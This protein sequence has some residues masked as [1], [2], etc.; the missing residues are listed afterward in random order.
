ISQHFKRAAEHKPPRTPLLAKAVDERHS[1]KI[2][3]YLAPNHIVKN[4]VAA[5]SADHDSSSGFSSMSDDDD[6]DDEDDDN[7]E[8]NHINVNIGTAASTN[9]AHRNLNNSNISAG[10]HAHKSTNNGNSSNGINISNPRARNENEDDSDESDDD[11]DV[12]GDEDDDDDDEDDEDEDDDDGDL[13]GDSTERKLKRR[14]QHQLYQQH[15]HLS[16]D[17]MVHKSRSVMRK[18]KKVKTWTVTNRPT[19]KRFKSKHPL[20]GSF[21]AST[22]TNIHPSRWRPANNQEYSESEDGDDESVEEDDDL[23]DD[24]DVF[25]KGDL[26]LMDLQMPEIEKDVHLPTTRPLASFSTPPP[27]L[28]SPHTVSAAI[29]ATAGMHGLLNATKILSFDSKKSPP[30]PGTQGIASLSDAMTATGSVDPMVESSDE[31]QDFSDYHE[32]MMHGDFDDLD[33]DKR[34]ED[35]RSGI[36]VRSQPQAVAVPIPSVR[37]AA[38]SSSSFAAGGTPVSP[39]SHL[40]STPTS[41]S[42]MG[43]SPR[44]RKMSM[45]GLLMPPDSLLLSPRSNSIFDSDFG[46]SLMVDYSQDTSSSKDHQYV[47]L[48]E[49]NNPE[50]M[51]VSELDRLLSSSAGGTF[52]PSLSR[53]V[54]ISGW[55]NINAKHIGH[56]PHRQSNLRNAANGILQNAANSSFNASTSLYL[57]TGG[58][59]FSSIS[60]PPSTMNGGTKVAVFAGGASAASL[61]P[62]SASKTASSPAT[63]PLPSQQFKAGAAVITITPPV[64]TDNFDEGKRLQEDVEMQGDADEALDDETESELED[65]DETRSGSGAGSAIAAEASKSLVREAVY[66]NL[67]VYETVMPGTDL[68]LMRIAGVVAPPDPN[69]NGRGVV[70]QKKVIPALNNEQHAGFVNA[71]MLRLAARTYI[72]DGQFDINQEPTTLFIVLEGPMEV[73]GAWVGLARAR[74]LCHEY[75]LDVI[76]GIAQ[77]LQDKPME[78]INLSELRAS[79]REKKLKQKRQAAKD[80]ASSNM[81]GANRRTSTSSTLSNLSI[82]EGRRKS[83]A[84]DDDTTPFVNFE[85]LEEKPKRSVDDDVEM[86]SSADMMMSSGQTADNLNAPAVTQQGGSRS[87]S[88]SSQ[89]TADGAV[90][91][92]GAREPEANQLWIPTTSPVVPNIHLTVIDNVA[93]YTTKLVNPGAEYRLL[94]RADNGYVNATTLL[95]AGGVETEQERS[96][97]LSLELGRVRVRKPGSQ[98][99]G[100]W[101]PLARARALAATC[102]LHHKLGPFL[103]DNLDTYFPSPLP[104]PTQKVTPSVV[105][106]TASALMSHQAVTSARMRTISLSALRSSTSPP[107]NGLARA[108]ALN[109]Q[110]SRGMMANNGAGHLQQVLGQGHVPGQPL[111]TMVMLNGNQVETLSGPAMGAAAAGAAGG[112]T[113]LSST[114]ANTGAN[115]DAAATSAGVAVA[116]SAP[117]PGMTSS[118]LNLTAGSTLLQQALGQSVSQGQLAA[119]AQIR[120]LQGG[121]IPRVEPH[122]GRPILPMIN[123][124]VSAVPGQSVIPVKDYQDSDDDT[125]SD[126]DVEDVRQKMKQLRAQ[127][128]EEAE[129]NLL[130]QTTTLANGGGVGA[131]QKAVG[132]QSQQQLT[133]QQQQQQQQQLLLQQQQIQQ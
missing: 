17:T 9:A 107:T 133:Q 126:D 29:S 70:I 76:P 84:A 75:Q 61:A 25:G 58:G 105:T 74:E 44:S 96:I 47:P 119:A 55:S 80:S 40:A 38:A 14:R 45:T 52:F 100:T 97:V 112:A 10:N 30:R 85:E 79:S 56:P 130:K 49:L 121:F 113:A 42:F 129:K 68:R 16:S 62:S 63:S 124:T 101:I 127:Q 35:R 12:E 18:R 111:S 64:D 21:K 132:I 23:D 122:T 88:I 51:P 93:L 125:E 15:Q 71:A 82:V 7:N 48:M 67:K 83:H 33:D 53:K 65:D 27:H 41:N 54:S 87:G 91:Q 11:D 95:L 69:M 102:S 4:P 116:G 86:S 123:E 90:A 28:N 36:A 120:P 72:G 2:H 22:P 32:E 103:N 50:S 20:I 92:N 77:M 109:H 37:N 89:G 78:V 117:V 31:E 98:L 5:T 114:S 24:D 43:M 13:S 131:G 34:T 60:S 57:G 26:V 94:R 66:A 115:L 81:E 46:S 3:Y 1:R 106:A 118:T 59:G 99:F 8:T 6:D 108:G 128:L 19:V 104:I 110:L 39:F 73:R